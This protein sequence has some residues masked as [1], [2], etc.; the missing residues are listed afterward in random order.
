VNTKL[1]T[2]VIA[3][4]GFSAA[5]MS[6]APHREGGSLMSK[7]GKPQTATLEV[8]G[9][10]LV[11]Q[12]VLQLIYARG[13]RISYEDTR[14]TYPDDL[15][16][17]TEQVTGSAA[18]T[19]RTR[20]VVPKSR[21]LSLD[22]DTSRGPEKMVNEIVSGAAAVN[23][24]ARFRV[25]K[26]GAML[27]VIPTGGRDKN[28]NA[29]S[30]GSPLDA[31]ISLPGGERTLDQAL[32]AICEAVAAASSQRV[33]IG[34]NGYLPYP[35]APRYSIAAN[36]ESARTVLL[37][38]MDAVGV[39]RRAGTWVLL[40][41]NP[42]DTYYLSI[43]PLPDFEAEKLPSTPAPVPVRAPKAKAKAPAQTKGMIDQ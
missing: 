41:D 26:N 8:E 28:G 36:N 14:V 13:D 34:S 2:C 30:E 39:E 43:I 5:A 27:H 9:G 16:D 33:T 23:P 35:E 4:I 29:T 32:K 20:I 10:R 25:E 3:L 22:L 38:L 15:E 21:K 18:Q 24:G 42:L 6:A 31:R 19:Q 17:I 11:E 7:A 40:Y 12:G 37:R 1:Q